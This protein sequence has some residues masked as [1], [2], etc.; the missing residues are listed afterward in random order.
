MYDGVIV[1]IDAFVVGCVAEAAVE[2]ASRKTNK[3]R[4]IAGV[5]TFSLKGIENLVNLFH[6]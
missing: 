2:V 3:H 4:R 1:H 6:R 5:M